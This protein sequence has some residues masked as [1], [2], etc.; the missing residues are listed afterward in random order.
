MTTLWT[1]VCIEQ[2]GDASVDTMA[3][4]FCKRKSS[5]VVGVELFEVPD[6]T[7]A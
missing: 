5:K 1:S 3:C 2:R 4:H 6:P 7:F